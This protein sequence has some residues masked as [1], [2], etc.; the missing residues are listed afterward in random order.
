MLKMDSGDNDQSKEQTEPQACEHEVS[1]YLCRDLLES[2]SLLTKCF[3]AKRKPF[4]IRFE[5]RYTLRERPSVTYSVQLCSVSVDPHDLPW[6]WRSSPSS[7]TWPTG[8]SG[9]GPCLPLQAH[10]A[11]SQPSHYG[12]M[13]FPFSERCHFLSLLN[14]LDSGA[15]RPFSPPVCCS[16]HLSGL[17]VDTAFS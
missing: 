11:P 3:K 2:R 10:P 6:P 5:A 4:P 12:H 15:G 13:E 8:P 7:L 17:C 14:F 16:Y 9:P 1:L